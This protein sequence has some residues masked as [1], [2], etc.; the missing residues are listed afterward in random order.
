MVDVG[1]HRYMKTNTCVRRYVC[2]AHLGRCFCPNVCQ[3]FQMPDIMDKKGL[4]LSMTA[5]T[6]IYE[7]PWQGN[8]P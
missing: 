3:H 1:D 6:I 2:P 8:I 7:R 4:S 5:Y